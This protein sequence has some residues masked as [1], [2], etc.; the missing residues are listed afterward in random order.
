MTRVHN[1]SQLNYFLSRPAEKYV[2]GLRI[3]SWS[4]RQLVNSTLFFHVEEDNL[5][6]TG[7]LVT[8]LADEQQ[9]FKWFRITVTSL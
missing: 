5:N 2:T 3:T 9:Q 1:L 8:P 4:E 6:I 7:H